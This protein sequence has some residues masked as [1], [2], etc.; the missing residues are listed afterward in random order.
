VPEAE[1]PLRSEAAALKASAAG[2]L[3]A[4]LDAFHFAP[5]VVLDLGAGTGRTARELRRRYPRALV[6]AL[7]RSA[8]MLR[9]AAREQRLWRR[10]ARVCGDALHLPLQD[11]SVDVAFSSLMLQ[12]CEPLEAALGEVRRVLKPEGL[13]AFSALGPATPTELRDAWAQADGCSHMSRLRDVQELGDALVRSGL[14]EPVLDVDRVALGCPGA[15]RPVICEIIYG[16]SWGAS[17]RPAAAV[18][19]GVAR[20]APGSIGRSRRAP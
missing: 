14:M 17:G 16:V 9:Q 12:W 7:D 19:D 8:E 10:F 11:A 15:Q 20:I 13:F 1:D 3:L 6:I 18:S 5:R 2:E 4:R